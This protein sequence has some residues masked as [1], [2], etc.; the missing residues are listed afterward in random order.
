[1]MM[2]TD[3]GYTPDWSDDFYNVGMLELDTES[4]AY[5]VPDVDYCIEQAHDW[6]HADGD[7]VDERDYCDAEDIANREVVVE[8]VAEI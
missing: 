4:G 1:M 3:G 2:W 5:I 6:Q 8:V 7:F